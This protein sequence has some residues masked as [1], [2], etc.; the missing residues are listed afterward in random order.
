MKEEEI[1]MEK[2]TITMTENAYKEVNMLKAKFSAKKGEALS[3]DEFFELLLNRERKKKDLTSW[4]YT[5]GIFIA[6]TF[7]FTFPLYIGAPLAAL[8]LIPMYLLI[9]FIVAFFSA[10]VLTPWSLRKEMR[11]FDSAPLQVLKSLEELSNRAGIKKVPKLMIK[12]TLEIN[13][14]AYASLSGDRVCV[15][16]GLMDAYQTGRIDEKELNAILGHELGHIRNRDSF[17]RGVVL[18]WISICD[19]MGNL[20]IIIGTAVG[21]TGTVAVAGSREERA[22]EFVMAIIGWASVIAGFIMKIIAKIASILAFHHSRRQEHAADEVAAEL[23]SPEV[24]ASALQK[25][26]DLNNELIAKELSIL[27]YSDRWQMQP[28]NTSWIDSLWDTHPPM[29]KRIS[30]LKRISEFL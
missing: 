2:V 22:F 17:R 29:E 16:K 4:L 27:P 19:T 25:I 28:R 30:E 24:A 5:L 11:P 8:S 10:Y 9:G 3:W 14:C 13:A 18:S 23:T 15:T 12:E 1:K 20:F 6:I 7:V 26:E 21:V